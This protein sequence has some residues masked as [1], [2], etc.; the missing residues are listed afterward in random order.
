MMQHKAYVFDYELFDHELRALLE[1]A[2]GSGDCVGLISFINGN[3]ASLADP[4]EGEPLVTDWEEMIETPDAHQYGDFALTKYYD[5]KADYGLGSDWDELQRLVT[6]D[7]AAAESP[8]LG[9]P[10]GPQD[11]LFDPGKMGSYFQSPKQVQANYAYL[12]QLRDNQ[13]SASLDEAIEMLQVP[14]DA[15]QGLYVTF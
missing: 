7:R 8:I 12:I 1:A 13:P 6:A 3:L 14:L 15:G 9:T 11:R 5:P 10:I 4:Y 2:L